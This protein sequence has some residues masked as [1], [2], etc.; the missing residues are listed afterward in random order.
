MATTTNETAQEP[1]LGDRVTFTGVVA[2]ETS[3]REG[4]RYVDAPPPCFEGYS[5]TPERKWLLNKHP[6]TEGVIVGKRLYR[7]MENDEGIW[8]PNGAQQFTAY[9]VAYTLNR[10]PVMVRL[11]Q[12]V[13]LS[14]E[15]GPDSERP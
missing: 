11:D 14:T 6:R 5:L 15:T 7:S 4:V 2:K 9:L 13:P 1:K 3:Y 10:N 12:M 8:V